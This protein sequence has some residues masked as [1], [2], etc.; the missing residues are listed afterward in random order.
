M[1][2][3]G[4]WVSAALPPAGGGVTDHGALT[5][6]GDDDHPQ[7]LLANGTRALSGNLSAGNNRI[8]NLAAGTGAGDA[9]RF[10][11]A[12]KQ[13]DPAGG[14]VTGTYPN[15]LRVSGLQGRPVIDSQ[16]NL[17]DALLWNGTAWQARPVVIPNVLPFASV[18]FLDNNIYFVWFNLDV[19]DNN[20][21][22]T[23]F[24]QEAVVV[25]AESINQ[26]EAF[27]TP[28]PVTQVAAQPNT[29]NQFRISLQPPQPNQ[30]EPDFLR[31]RFDLA[32]IQV[33]EG[34][35]QPQT[36]LVHSNATNK[37]FVGFDGRRF[38]TVFVR[39]R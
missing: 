33:T 22:V 12:I 23:T 38:V 32:R 14:D 10:E 15:Q 13:N 26:A 5:G 24:T 19:P 4:A 21:L 35:N 17:N 16:P 37:R 7:Y 11:Q 20:V 29:R 39:R 36:L 34:Q 9:V 27:L 6:L 25:Q 18:R 1:R 3:G 28:V 8:T 2:Q 31:F 30:P